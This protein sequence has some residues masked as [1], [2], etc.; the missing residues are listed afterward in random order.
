MMER[1]NYTIDRQI[2]FFCDQKRRFGRSKRNAFSITIF[3][4]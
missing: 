1:N 4:M 2:V 3:P